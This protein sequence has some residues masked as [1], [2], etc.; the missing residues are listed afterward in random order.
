MQIFLQS[1]SPGAR[2][3]ES[4]GREI[5]HAEFE[6]V[7]VVALAVDFSWEPIPPDPGALVQ[8]EIQVQPPEA[9]AELLTATWDWDDGQVLQQR[10]VQRRA[11]A[12]AQGD[13]VDGGAL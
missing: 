6:V 12:D 9:A 8:L 4:P 3:L 11:G 7:P 1:P 5:E 2:V 13:R 10:A